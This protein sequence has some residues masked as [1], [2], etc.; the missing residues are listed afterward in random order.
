MFARTEG[1]IPAPESNHAIQ[2]CITEALR[3]KESGEPKTLFF[4]LSG[5]GHFDMSAY[6]QYFSGKLED[7]EYPQVEIDKALTH[8]PKVTLNFGHNNGN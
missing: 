4:N 8:L 7:F 1:I 6:D 2:A 5:H 3:C